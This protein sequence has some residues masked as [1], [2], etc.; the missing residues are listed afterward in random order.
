[1]QSRSFQFPPPAR[2]DGK[3]KSNQR[4]NQRMPQI[5]QILDFGHN[6]ATP[7]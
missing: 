6:L 4:R 2:F 3:V 5:E 1:V 7:D